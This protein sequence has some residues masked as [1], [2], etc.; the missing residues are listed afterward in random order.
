MNWPTS[1]HPHFFMLTL[2]T[3]FIFY[4]KQK[5]V[6]M[7]F[8]VT[9]RTHAD[10]RQAVF[11]AFSQMTAEDDKRDMGDKIR[12][13]G[14]WHDLSQFSGVAICECDDAL[15]VASW[16]LNWNNVLDLQ[17]VVVLDDEEARAVGKNKLAA[18][19]QVTPA[20]IAN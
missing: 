1:L 15:A 14:R 11:N 16:A 10:K 17:T 6:S 12:L 3:V 13:I 18:A 19:A 2:D 7:K 20:S 8:M 5:E 9:W 4:L